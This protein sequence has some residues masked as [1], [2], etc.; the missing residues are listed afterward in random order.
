MLPFRTKPTH[1]GAWA[2]LALAMLPAFGRTADPAVRIEPK[3]LVVT[4]LPAA[5]LARPPGFDWS[6]V[7]AVRVAGPGDK[8]VLAGQYHAQGPVLRFEPR[9]PFVPG[10]KYRV[11]LNGRDTEVALPEPPAGPPTEVAHVYPTTD[12][13]PENQL[14]FYIHFSAAMT[15][16]EA[17]RHVHL[18]GENG[19]E[20][21]HPFLELGEE[22]WNPDG[23]RFTLFFDPGRIKRG[24]KPREEVGP[25]LLEGK[26]YTLVIDADWP[27]ANGK[28]LKAAFRK[29]FAA[30]PPDDTQPTLASWKLTVPA[31]GTL[32]SLT[33][34]FPKPMDHALL[35]RMIWVV[36]TKDG[37]VA[38]TIAMDERETRWHFTPEK[39]WAAGEYRLKIDAALEDLA[40]NSLGRP[41]EVDVLHPAKPGPSAEVVELRFAVR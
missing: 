24:L 13:L 3:G 40:G 27:D 34:V 4:G 41:F 19:R 32:E 7:L 11:T 10:V 5:A 6:T 39:A 28:P 30:G 22:L 38:G 35:H 29:A 20:V 8:P 37:R 9:Y 1:R 18:I 31:A 36:D 33:V 25:S 21:E 16:G 17:Y 14:K 15:R 26:R 23:T 2:L 12:R